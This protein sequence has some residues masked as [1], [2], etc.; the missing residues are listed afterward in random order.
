MCGHVRAT[1][2]SGRH[3]VGGP[4]RRLHGIPLAFQMGVQFDRVLGFDGPFVK[5]TEFATVRRSRAD[6]DGD[7]L[8]LHAPGQQVSWPSIVCSPP[9]KR[10]LALERTHG[11]RHPV[12]LGQTDD[13][14][15]DSR[16][17]PDLASPSGHGDATV[18][19]SRG[20]A[21][22]GLAWSITTATACRPGWTRLI[23]IRFPTR[24]P[25]RVFPRTSTPAT[26]LQAD[27]LVFNNRHG[28]APAAGGG[29]RGRDG[30]R[31]AAGA[32]I[33]G[34]RGDGRGGARRRRQ[35][36]TV[37]VHFSRSLRNTRRRGAL[38]TAGV[39]A[40]KQFVKMAGRSSRS[41]AR[42]TARLNVRTRSP[43]M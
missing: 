14:G 35:A 8:L 30:P 5:L 26:A 41:A 17:R 21:G 18:G 34:G 20:S 31:G 2:S 19:P 43:R 25:R 27:V 7:R 13:F 28:V 39:A 23:Q 24:A 3:S 12:R 37:R 4:P 9:T 16:R 1:G 36:T 29:G 11:L 22:R 40:W 32:A 38:T 6:N 33:G 42:P 15:A 10:C